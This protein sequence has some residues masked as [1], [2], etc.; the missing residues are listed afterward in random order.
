VTKQGVNERFNES[1]VRLLKKLLQDQLQGQLTNVVERESL[2]PLLKPFSAVKVKDSTRF[3]LPAHLR[4]DYPG[5]TGASSGAGLHIQFEF[6]VLS[7]KVIDLDLTDAMQ[8]DNTDAKQKVS[9]IEPGDL[10]LRDL[11][12]F[13][14]SVLE[15][16]DRE[17][18]YFITRRYTNMLLHDVDSGKQVNYDALYS[19]M[20]DQGISFVE[21][22]V[23]TTNN[24]N[25]RLIVEMLP[26]EQVDRKLAKAKIQAGKKGGSGRLTQKYRSMARLNMFLTNVPTESISGEDVRKLYRLR[27]Q[28]ELC[29]KGWKSFYNIDHVKEMKKHRFEC[30]LYGKLLILMVNWEIAM[31]YRAFLLRFRGKP[32]SILKFLKATSRNTA[33]LTK[34]L[35]I[36]GR[37]LGQH[38]ES[39][40]QSSTKMLCEKKKDHTAP[41]EEILLSILA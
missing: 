9:T 16:I 12:Y 20:K 40:Y 15:H 29:F 26:Q 24:L 37:A 31:T 39:L 14:L 30:Y 7:G 35:L 8:Q 38:L 11:G 3:Q 33:A 23:R 21:L 5:S 27:W 13:S 10:I 19:R 17:K 6:D 41:L 32:L 36:G 28:I 25:L 1:A 22:P 2:S 34:A 18:A 4:K